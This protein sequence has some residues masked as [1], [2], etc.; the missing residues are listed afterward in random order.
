[1]LYVLIDVAYAR[2]WILGSTSGVCC[3]VVMLNPIPVPVAVVCVSV[4]VL[5]EGRGAAGV[6]VGRISVVVECRE[7]CFTVSI[8]MRMRVGGAVV[9][10]RVMLGWGGLGCLWSVWSAFAC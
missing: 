8:G 9:V 2:T 7:R 3:W 4:L 6:G 10:V 5:A 1:M